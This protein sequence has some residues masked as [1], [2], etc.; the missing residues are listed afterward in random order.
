MK[1]AEDWEEFVLRELEEYG[2]A[3]RPAFRRIKLF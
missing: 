1:A 3:E 2:D